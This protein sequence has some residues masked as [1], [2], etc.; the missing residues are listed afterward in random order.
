MRR[1]LLRTLPVITIVGALLFQPGTAPLPVK[2]FD[3]ANLPTKQKRLLSGFAHSALTRPATRAPQARNYF[4]VADRGCR[5]HLGPNVKVNQDCL[6]LS[7]QDLP[8]RGQAHNETSIAQDPVQSNHIVASFNDY[9]RGDGTCAAAYSLDAGQTWTDSAV[10]AAFTRA[11]PAFAA[12]ASGITRQYWQASG[13]TSVAWDTRGNAY[14]ACQVLQRG[15]ADTT[16]SDMSSGVYL[17]RSTQNFGASWDF[18]G[19]PVIESADVMGTGAAAFEDKPYMTVDNQ[20]GSPFADRIYVT[21]TEFSSS[22]VVIF[23]SFSNDFGEHFSPRVLVSTSSPTLCPNSFTTAGSCDLSTDSQPF[24]GPDGTLYVVYSNFNNLPVDANDNRNQILLSKSTDGGRTFTGPVKVADWF[25]VPDCATYQQGLNPGR[26]CVPEK[27][28]ATANSFFRVINYA[29][30]AVN[31]TLAR[32]VVVAFASYINPHSNEATGCFPN[33]IAADGFN[34]YT[35]VKAPGTC[36]NDILLSVSNDGGLSFTGTTID[37]R[38]LT[39]VTQDPGQATTD[40]WWQWVAFTKTGKLAV[41]Y[42]D[43]QYGDDE[44]TGFSDVSLSSSTDLQHF[45][46]VRVTSRSMPPPTQ[47]E[48]TFFGDYAG[49]TAVLDAHPVWMDT[50][51]PDLFLCPGTATSAMPPALCTATA[52]NASLANDQDIFT[53]TVGVP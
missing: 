11:V 12:A 41:S 31:P 6:T 36:N 27:N 13:D 2:A 15:R 26:D 14:L 20:V 42:Y 23:A 29:S 30:G 17:F 32:Q 28:P 40:Q 19:R 5:L 52:L 35:G 51:D 16:S 9:R 37:P 47:F 7:D 38:R 34:L 46:T 21:Y 4:P 3:P 8:G 10:P 33:G 48:G 53:A 22:G 1:Q 49:L 50:R 18:P 44:F 24:T 25:D 39:S 43:R 45:T